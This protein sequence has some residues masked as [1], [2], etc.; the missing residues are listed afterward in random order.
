[1]GL[2]LTPLAAEVVQWGRV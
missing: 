2:F 1:M